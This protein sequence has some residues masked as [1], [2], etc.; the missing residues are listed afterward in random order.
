[1]RIHVSSLGDGQICLETDY[2][3]IRPAINVVLSVSRFGLGRCSQKLL[4]QIS[5]NQ[6]RRDRQLNW[7]CEKEEH[8][9]S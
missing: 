3:G 4:R 6:D 5:T 1:M 7:A 2:R 8:D 9:A